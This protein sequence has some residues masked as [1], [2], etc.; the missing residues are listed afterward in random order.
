[1]NK[2]L[3]PLDITD[4][5][6]ELR[7]SSHLSALVKRVAELR[8]AGLMACHCAEE[9]YLRW[10]HPL[11]RRERVAYD[12]PQLADPSPEPANGEIFNLIFDTYDMVI[13][14]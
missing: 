8:E 6:N 10:I 2:L 13:L 11:G 14:T 1:V 4:K 9:F 5:R 12:C 7:M 3:F